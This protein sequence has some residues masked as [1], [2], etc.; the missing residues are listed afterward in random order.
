MQ[1]MTIVSQRQYRWFQDLLD[2]LQKTGQETNGEYSQHDIQALLTT[3]EY[4]TLRPIRMRQ[5]ACGQCGSPFEAKS[6]R[7]YHPECPNRTSKPRAT[8]KSERSGLHESRWRVWIP[9][10]AMFITVDEAVDHYETRALIGA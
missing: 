4:D 10:L 3:V 5:C 2:W 6:G 9:G 7:K 1:T 8:P